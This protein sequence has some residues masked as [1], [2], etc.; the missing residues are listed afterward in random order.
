MHCWL[1]WVLN[2]NTGHVSPQFHVVVDNNYSK[3]L[4]MQLVKEP[5]HWLSLVEQAREKLTDEKFT[6][7][8]T[9]DSPLVDSSPAH[10]LRKLPVS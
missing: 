2:P 5:S 4:F 6:I 3:L 1:P 7:T 10:C 8:E 9:W